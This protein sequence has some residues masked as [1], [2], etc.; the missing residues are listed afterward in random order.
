[1]KN[2]INKY[3]FSLFALEFLIKI[4]TAISYATHKLA[5]VSP[6][7]PFPMYPFSPHYQDDDWTKVVPTLF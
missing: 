6:C 2:K 5:H 1:M 4:L 3:C 7:L